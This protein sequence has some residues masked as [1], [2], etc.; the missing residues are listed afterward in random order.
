MLHVGNSST[1]YT[2]SICIGSIEII[3]TCYMLLH[4]DLAIHTVAIGIANM[5]DYLE[6]FSRP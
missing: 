2:R 3:Y 1:V 6:S 5:F 4:T